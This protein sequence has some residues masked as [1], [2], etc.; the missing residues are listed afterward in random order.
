MP[1]TLSPCG[2]GDDNLQLYHDI[3]GLNM[4]EDASLP[5]SG[6]HI[7]SNL[8]ARLSRRDEP[9]WATNGRRLR[10][11]TSGP[12]RTTD[13]SR[14]ARLV[15]F[16]P[17]RDSCTAA[18]STYSITSSALASSV[19]GIARLNA[20]ATF[21]FMTSSNF[22]GCSTGRLAGDAPLE[23]CRHNLPP[24]GSTV[25][26]PVHTRIRPPAAAYSLGPKIAGSRALATSSVV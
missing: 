3:N 19:R 11:A 18:I 12:P 1:S 26:D 5:K 15:R 17:T 4:L 8:W 23:S 16:V 9:V 20:F 13:I 2:E 24:C 25:S 14:P 21:R 7:G 10:T 22:V 6:Q